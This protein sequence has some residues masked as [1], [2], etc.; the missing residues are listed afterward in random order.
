M[1]IADDAGRGCQSGAGGP[2]LDGAAFAA[3]LDDG[4]VLERF[5]GETG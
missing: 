5:T 1:R 3:A 2:V 4:A